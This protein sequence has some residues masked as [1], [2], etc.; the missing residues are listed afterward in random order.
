MPAKTILALAVVATLL[1]ATA[2]FAAEPPRSGHVYR[3][4]WLAEQ[5][6]ARGMQIC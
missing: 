5:A 4:G 6:R 3:V 1:S 2:S